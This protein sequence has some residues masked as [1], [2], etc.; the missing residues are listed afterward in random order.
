[1]LRPETKN[2]IEVISEFLRTNQNVTYSLSTDFT[3]LNNSINVPINSTTELMNIITTINVHFGF[4]F[5][6]NK[7]ISTISIVPENPIN[8][9]LQSNFKLDTQETDL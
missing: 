1:M 5:F 4:P 6:E 7:N 8:L 2:K 9:R 3:Q